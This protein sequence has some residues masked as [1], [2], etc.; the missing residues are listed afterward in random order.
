MIVLV[1]IIAYVF[2]CIAF[3]NLLM[4][5]FGGFDQPTKFLRDD[6]L[7]NIA[8][9]VA[10]RNEEKNIGKCLR[11]L[12]AQ[13][14]PKEKISIFVGNDQSTDN[15]GTIVDEFIRREANISQ[16]HIKTLLG[17]ARGKANVLAHLAHQTNAEYFL[18]TDA[19]IETMPAW[20]RNLVSFFQ[21]QIGIVSGT[22]V[23]A[24]S[25]F[26]ARM[27]QIDWLYFMGLLLSFDKI[28]LASTAV[29]NNMAIKRDAYFSTGGYEN[30]EFSVTE[31]HKL[32]QQIRNM[33]W[34]TINVLD[35]GSVNFSAPAP[36]FRTLLNQRKR[37]LTGAKELPFY[38]WLIF[39]IYG[40]FVPA[41]V[42]LF[43]I[44][45][46]LALALYFIKL[47]IQSATVSIQLRSLHLRLNPLHLL[48]YEAYTI[49]I[50]LCTVLYFSL[51][52][53]LNWKDRYY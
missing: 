1:Y 4:K 50:T 32:F 9:F 47:I 25:G 2:L 28:G 22:T 30:F 21:P 49:A 5:A 27:Q 13:N 15:T 19:D 3:L 11:S 40:S 10:A 7:P 36:N 31:D 52:G 39:G 46:N 18:I 53:K 38:W 6:E 35:P 41:I 43:F 14:Y 42:A 29:G 34:K 12:I 45:P 26:S 37:W 51:P 24:G 17:K 8:V 16:V 44:N 23:V 20:A 33:G 48:Y